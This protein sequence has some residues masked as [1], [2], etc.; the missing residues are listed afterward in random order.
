MT[1]PQDEITALRAR[2]AELEQALRNVQY[3]LSHEFEADGFETTYRERCVGCGRL[4]AEG[5]KADCPVCE[6]LK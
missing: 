3:V 5:C 1:D 2:V 6:A 4:S